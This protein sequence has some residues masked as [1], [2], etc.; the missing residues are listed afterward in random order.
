MEHAVIARM[1]APT[2]PA[3]SGVRSSRAF[4]LVAFALSVAIMGNNAPSPIYPIFQQRFGLSTGE[5]T[6]VFAAVVIG[7]IPSLLILGPASDRVGRRPLLA[8]ALTMALLGAV[9]FTIANSLGSLLVARVLQGVSFGALSG[10]AV[11]A[12]VELEPTADHAR[13]TLT[14]TVTVVASQ[15]IAPL[16]AGVLAQYAPDPARLTFFALAALLLAALAGLALV[17]ETVARSSEPRRASAQLV[18]VTREIR[19]QFFAASLAV[20]CS[21]GALGLVAALGP[22]FVAALLAVHNLAVGGAVVFA[23]L[24]AS[25]VAQ[26]TTRHWPPRAQLIRGALILAGGLAI[27]LAGVIGGSLAPFLIGITVAGVGQG[28]AYL[29]AQSLLDSVVP[30]EQRA[31]VM[32]AF[33]LVLYMAAALSAL[34]VGLSSGALGLLTATVVV[35]SVLIAL[36]AASAAMTTV[37]VRA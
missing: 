5:L 7:V 16:A 17:P 3:Q 35:T 25:A 23:M 9:G 1:R 30:A 12:L 31:S 6:L 8:V 37:R 14:A 27:L 36:T 13:A 11:A 2:A 22:K 29:G 32:S 21:F 34:A 19:T 33:F 10:T 20:I 15:A 28:L 26:L 4:W 18:G 24:A